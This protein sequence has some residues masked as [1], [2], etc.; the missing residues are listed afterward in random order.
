MTFN[1]QRDADVSTNLNGIGTV[2]SKPNI[3]GDK[4]SDMIAAL[5]D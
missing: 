5:A 1:K 2:M 4:R 3:G